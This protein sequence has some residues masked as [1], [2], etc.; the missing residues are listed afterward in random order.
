[1]YLYVSIALF[2]M[3]GLYNWLKRPF[4]IG[5]RPG[6]NSLISLLFGLF[7]FAFLMIFD[8]FPNEGSGLPLWITSIAYGLITTIIMILNFILLPFLIKS[9]FQPDNYTVGSAL[10]ASLWNISIIAIA[11]WFFYRYAPSYTEESRSL[12]YFLGATLSLGIFPVIILLFWFER[13]YFIRYSTKAE[14]ISN[15]I[16]SDYQ[17]INNTEL[18]LYGEGKT[19]MMRLQS[20][21]LICLKSEGN[22][23]AVFYRSEEITKRELLRG[24]LKTFEEQLSDQAQFIRCHQSYIINRQLLEDISGNARGYVLDLK[25]FDIKVPVSRQ[26]EVSRLYQS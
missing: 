18:L 6:R 11:N 5:N 12:L 4:P 2:S 9:Q 14:N 1:M 20:S 22:Y 3:I 17:N 10:L 23:V 16:S 15:H 24:A 26:F 21:G 13:V 8:P 25:N 19:E 7:I